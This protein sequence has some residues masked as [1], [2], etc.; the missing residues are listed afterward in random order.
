M[1][2]LTERPLVEQVEFWATRVIEARDDTRAAVAA[3]RQLAF[4]AHALAMKVR[5]MGGQS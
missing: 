2:K 5:A 4:A 3:G 1:T